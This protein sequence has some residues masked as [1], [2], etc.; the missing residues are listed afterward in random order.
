MPTNQNRLFKI[1]TIAPPKT[2]FPNNPNGLPNIACA[3]SCILG[4]IKISK[5]AKTT[6]QNVII[7][8]PGIIAPMLFYTAGGTV[9][10]NF[11]CIFLLL[12]H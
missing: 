6:N 7:I 5:N 8:V 11:I 2:L 4:S 12:N 1:T 10:G 9:P 3:S